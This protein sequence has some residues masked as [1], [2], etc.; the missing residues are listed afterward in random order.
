MQ[1]SEK[2]DCLI[3]YFNNS[4]RFLKLLEKFNPKFDNCDIELVR[5]LR[6][7]QILSKNIHRI[8]AEIY[9]KALQT[10]L[11]SSNRVT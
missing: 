5:A 2:N 11:K 8:D 3:R 10:K 9:E 7:L 1:T 4:E 6:N